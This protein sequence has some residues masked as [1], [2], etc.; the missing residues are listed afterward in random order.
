MPRQSAGV[1]PSRAA[2]TGSSTGMHMRGELREVVDGAPGRGEVEVEQAHRHAVAEH[3]VLEAHVVVAH[4]GAAPGV[5]HLVA[6]RG[7]RRVERPRRVV[8]PAQQRRDRGE[9]VVG[10]RPAGERRHRHVALDEPQPLTAVVVDADRHRGPVEARVVQ[11]A[12]EAVDG[13]R[14]GVRRPQHV[15][16]RRASPAPRWPHRPAA[17]PR[18]PAWPR[19]LRRGSAGCGRPRARPARAVRRARAGAPRG[20]DPRRTGCRWAGPARSRRGGARWRAG[21]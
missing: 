6:P 15:R 3:H 8:E 9:R 21:R 2:L 12:E 13:P 5:D 1:N 14:V 10:L 11:G 4:D 18:P 19:G 7:A 16:A 17:P 20:R